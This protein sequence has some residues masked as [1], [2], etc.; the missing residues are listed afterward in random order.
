MATAT[1]Q[2]QLDRDLK[3]QVEAKLISMGLDLPAVV[4]LLARQIVNQNRIPFE[5]VAL[6][7]E[8]NALTLEAMAETEAIL[9]HPERYKSYSSV[10]EI[11]E[12]IGG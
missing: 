9:A 8:P 2:V 11:L 1:I 6:E 7:E 12:D 3:E 10:R 4:N 5:I